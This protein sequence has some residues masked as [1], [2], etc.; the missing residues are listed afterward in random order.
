MTTL[1][2]L[3]TTLEGLYMMFRVT[4]KGVQR[5]ANKQVH[6]HNQ[7]H[8]AFENG[9]G[10]IM[11]GGAAF[12]DTMMSRRSHHGIKNGLA[13]ANSYRYAQQQQH[14]RSSKTSTV[15]RYSDLSMGGYP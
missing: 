3:L 1:S 15:P 2:I 12:G 10:S 4:S 5:R 7:T 8:Y 9:N 11:N 13:L 6:N 14:Q